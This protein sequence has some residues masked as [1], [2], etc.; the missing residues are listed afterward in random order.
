MAFDITNYIDFTLA[1]TSD[2]CKSGRFVQVNYA[3]CLGCEE[4]MPHDFEEAVK[5]TIRETDDGCLAFGFAVADSAQLEC[6]DYAFDGVFNV[7]GLPL[8]LCIADD[9]NPALLLIV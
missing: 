8:G 5:R 3:S 9:G 2:G 1:K 4:E 7:N 6:S